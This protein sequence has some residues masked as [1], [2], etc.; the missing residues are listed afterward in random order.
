MA[1][2]ALAIQYKRN[3]DS[4]PNARLDAEGIRLVCE[5]EKEA[6][7][8]LKQSY[9]HYAYSVRARTKI[10]KVAR[11]IADMENMEKID[12]AHVAEAV[13]YRGFH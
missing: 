1:L 2:S 11:T 12:A 6:E 5:M 4:I 9:E 8:V 10:I 13:A 7:K 3:P